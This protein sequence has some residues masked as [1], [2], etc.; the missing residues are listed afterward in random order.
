M[1]IFLKGLFQASVN[2]VIKENSP[3]DTRCM[4]PVHTRELISCGFHVTVF[5]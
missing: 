5:L 3:F 4:L 1:P 2:R